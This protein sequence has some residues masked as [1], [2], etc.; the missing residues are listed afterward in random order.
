MATSKPRLAARPRSSSASLA[1]KLLRGVSNVLQGN[2]WNFQATNLAGSSLGGGYEGA[3]RQRRLF[4]FRPSEAGINSLNMFSGQT[5]RARARYLVRN[6]PYARKAQRVFT[7]NLIGT[8][9]RPIPQPENAALK[10]PISKLWNDW[11]DEA[12]ADGLTDLY[13]LE[14]LVGNAL[15]EAGE[16][17]IRRRPRLPRDGLTVPMQIQLLESEFCPYELNFVTAAGNIVKSGIEFNP[18]GQR[19]AYYFWKT[20]PGEYAMITNQAGWTRVPADD[21][22]HVF[23]PVRPGQIRGVSWL[24]TA[25]VTAYIHDQY[26]DA[27][28]ARKLTAALFAG[29]ITRPNNSPDDPP[30]ASQDQPGVGVRDTSTD[31]DEEV[32]AG[33]TPGT[34]QYL[35]DGEQITFSEP[36]DVGPN[37]EAFEYR[38]LLKLCA[39]M[40]MPYASVTGDYSKANY[41]SLRAALLDMR[42]AVKQLQRTVIFQMC[43]PVYQWF[44]EDAV[45]AGA[46]PVKASAFN[47]APRDFTRTQWQPPRQEWVDPQKDVDAEI[48][49]IRAGL[50]SREAV[51]FA[52][53]GRTMEEVDAS[54]A[55]SNASADAH[56]L[57]LDSDPR[58]TNSRGSGVPPDVGL[59][60]QPP[61]ETPLAE[62]D[63]TVEDD[64]TVDDEKSTRPEPLQA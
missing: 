43:R 39:G 46:L 54:A 13:G 28:L 49:A 33:L 22:L 48:K 18:I 6:N 34:M 36:A 57:I 12:D 21:V 51:V 23:K 14:E 2:A 31:A 38:A 19:V 8:G 40:D 1:Q 10:T 45:L 16:V 41:S 53:T 58:W 26:Q 61:A 7:S 44:V 15:F 3:Q 50:E 9:I 11:V 56:G 5:L 27:E 60:A 42:S 17:F 25:I 32:V 62:K 35:N 52:R 29:F 20:H 37:Y 55:R 63:D 47:A 24:T 64:S 4:G 30:I 59:A